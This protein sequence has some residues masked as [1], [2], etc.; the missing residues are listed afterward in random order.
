MESNYT[1]EIEAI[2]TERLTKLQEATQKRD[3]L[4][5][6]YSLALPFPQ[7]AYVIDGQCMISYEVKE[8]SNIMPLLETYSKYHVDAKMWHPNGCSPYFRMSPYRNDT[9]V[10]AD[11]V[12]Y[13][14][15]TWKYSHGIEC[16]LDFY[17]ILGTTLVEVRIKILNPPVRV[18]ERH[19]CSGKTAKSHVVAYKWR[20]YG[21]ETGTTLLY[22]SSQEHPRFTEFWTG[23]DALD[24]EDIFVTHI[25]KN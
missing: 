4:A 22:E 13:V 17:V 18:D 9:S 25:A 1:K 15:Q 12:S 24:L 5:T 6:M 7:Y 3:L 20:Y 10:Y 8:L 21:L 23:I 11:D 19:I 16:K 2:E 14:L